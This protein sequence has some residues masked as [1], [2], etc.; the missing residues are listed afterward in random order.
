MESK[1]QNNNLGRK[2][3]SES[4]GPRKDLKGRLEPTRK[5]KRQNTVQ[6]KEAASCSPPQLWHVAGS[7][8]QRDTEGK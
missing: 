2:G 5:P 3:G 8:L 4:L 7:N 1:I 6:R